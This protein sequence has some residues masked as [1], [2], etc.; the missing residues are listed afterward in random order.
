MK[1]PSPVSDVRDSPVLDVLD[2]LREAIFNARHVLRE[3]GARHGDEHSRRQSALLAIDEILE[4]RP[5]AAFSAEQLELLESLFAY[6]RE[7]EVEAE[8]A[9][10]DRSH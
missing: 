1:S 9:E 3:H 4:R 6:W 7:C 5:L 8:A 2:E 10:P